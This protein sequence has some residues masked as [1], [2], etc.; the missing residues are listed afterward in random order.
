MR[1]W[2]VYAWRNNDV[3]DVDDG[4]CEFRCFRCF[5]IFVLSDASFVYSGFE[6]N[7]SRVEFTSMF[8]GTRLFSVRISALRPRGLLFY[9]LSGFEVLFE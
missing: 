7:L 9:S 4:Y 5:K 8:V 2:C 6:D 1:V 3:D